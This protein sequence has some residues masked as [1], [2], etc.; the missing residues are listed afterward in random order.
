[1]CTV[2][3]RWSA[4]SDFPVQMLALRDELITRSFD[5]PGAWW[6]GEPDVI[7]GRDRQA[8]GSWCVS[9][10]RRGVTGVVLNRPERR[11]AAA[12]AP[13]RGVLPL[14]AVRHGQAWPQQLE[15]DGMA[16]F[17]LVLASPNALHWWAFDGELLS[18]KLL[19][20]GTYMFTPGG[21]LRS[22]LDPRFGSS[23]TAFS[24]DLDAAT[25]QAWPQW[26][27][28]VNDAKPSEDPIDLLV[29][30]PIDNDVFATVFGQFIAARPGAL[31][32]DQLPDP[33]SRAPWSTQLWRAEAA[34]ISVRPEAVSP[35]A[36]T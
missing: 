12:G 17:N 1:V 6:P 15:L 11:E 26:L 29:R 34:G 24:G 8:G 9:D 32:L 33:G 31:R 23:A 36:R 10:V 20:E 19:R 14:L 5:L 22:G 4:G 25:P 13:S 21:L 28:V 35:Q 16:S 7:G 2:V 18:H 30:M 27:E 3:C